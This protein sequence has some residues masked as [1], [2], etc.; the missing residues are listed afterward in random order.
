V[1]GE[2]FAPGPGHLAAV[3]CGLALALFG[4]ILLARAPAAE[5]AE[6]ESAVAT[7]D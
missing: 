1:F 5:P 7:E 2:T 3:V 4:V 6:A